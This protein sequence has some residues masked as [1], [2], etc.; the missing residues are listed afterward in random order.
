LISNDILI[1]LLA[2]LRRG[3]VRSPKHAF[4]A[5]FS[6][7]S[8]PR[9]VGRLNR[10]RGGL[11]EKAALIRPHEAHALGAEGVWPGHTCSFSAI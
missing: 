1:V 11:H 6:C 3:W 9:E 2:S 5:R 7:I 10:Q 8:S 4:S